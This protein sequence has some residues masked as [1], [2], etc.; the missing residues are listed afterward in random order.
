MNYSVNSGI[1][2]ELKD[3]PLV[4]LCK[5]NRFEKSSGTE[6]NGFSFKIC[7]KTL[8]V[9]TD[10][11]S[12]ISTDPVLFQKDGVIVNNEYERTLQEGLSKVEHLMIISVSKLGMLQN[13]K[14]SNFTNNVVSIEYY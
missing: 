6:L 4:W 2:N 14:V 8:H 12:C 7:N 11:G 9:Q 5:D 13:F 1:P 3:D 10:V